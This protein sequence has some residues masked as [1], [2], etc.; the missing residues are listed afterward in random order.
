MLNSGLGSVLLGG[1]RL[2]GT[3][4]YYTGT[5]LPLTNSTAFGLFSGRSPAH[6]TTYEGWVADHDEPNWLG[7]DRYFNNPESFAPASLQDVNRLGNATR[8]NP[9]ARY[10]W[11]MDENFSL[12]KQ[13]QFTEST[14]LDFRWEVFNALNRSR[15][16]PGST[17]IQD[18]NFGRVNSTINDPR[19]MQ[20]ALKL[21]W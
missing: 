7:G 4:F 16:N 19:R 1:W 17:N 5:P 15:F 21:Y 11:S 18:L 14:R 2:S 13:F 9:K 12:A 6:I 8:F 3:H 10:P 20:F